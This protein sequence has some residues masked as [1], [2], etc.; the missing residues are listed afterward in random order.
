MELDREKSYLK[1]QSPDCPTGPF[2][3]S[4]PQDQEISESYVAWNCHET[5]LEAS[6][7]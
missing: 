4:E 2:A 6:K 7:L 3:I 1:A 5:D